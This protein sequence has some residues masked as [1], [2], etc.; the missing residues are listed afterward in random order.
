MLR[1]GCV[2]G[3]AFVEKEQAI[4]PLVNIASL[5]PRQDSG[6]TLGEKQQEEKQS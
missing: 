2:A 4:V 6:Q 3:T 1:N 5:I